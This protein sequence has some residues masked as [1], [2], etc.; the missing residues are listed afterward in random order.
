MEVSDCYYSSKEEFSKKY[1]TL[2]PIQHIDLT[3][4]LMDE[5]KNSL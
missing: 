5:D 2:I 3:G 4:T 1:N